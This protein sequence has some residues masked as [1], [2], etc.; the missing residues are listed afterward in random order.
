MVE[1]LAKQHSHLE[2]SIRKEIAE[3][4][5]STEIANGSQDLASGMSLFRNK[6]FVLNEMFQRNTSKFA[7]F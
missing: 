1:Q 2:N 5:E 4:H 3:H 7:I 6:R